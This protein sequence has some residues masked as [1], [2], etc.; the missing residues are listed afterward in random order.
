MLVVPGMALPLAATTGSSL[1]IWGMLFLMSGVLFLYAAERFPALYA[2]DNNRLRE[3]L[4]ES[5][6]PALMGA[7]ALSSCIAL[8]AYFNLNNPSDPTLL[9][10][11][12]LCL[13]YPFAKRIP[14]LKN[15]LVP[16]VWWVALFEIALE[17]GGGPELSSAIGL[18]VFLLLFVGVLF[19]DIKEEVEEKARNQEPTL[20]ALIGYERALWLGRGLLLTILPIL[21]WVPAPLEW[22]IITGLLIG[23][24]FR[25]VWLRQELLGPS[26]VDGALGIPGLLLWLLYRC[27]GS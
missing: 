20:Q 8:I 3:H 21:F 9:A 26:F 23:L 25:Q 1:S 16:L 10:L 14:T 12:A 7:L 17:P 4:L 6:R 27:M 2:N 22:V 24:S 19:C 15:I 5:H 18:V 11:V 13:L